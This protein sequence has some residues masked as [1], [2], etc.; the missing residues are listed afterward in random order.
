MLAAALALNP[1]PIRVLEDPSQLAEPGRKT[2][3]FAWASW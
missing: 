2:I 3:V 1:I